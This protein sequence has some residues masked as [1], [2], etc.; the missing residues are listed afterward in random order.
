MA[1]KI[2]YHL[3]T[4][5]Y[6]IVKSFKILNFSTVM[7]IEICCPLVPKLRNLKMFKMSFYI[8]FSAKNVQKF[9]FGPLAAPKLRKEGGEG[10]IMPFQVKTSFQIQGRIGLKESDA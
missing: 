10:G 2:R 9:G 3:W 4:V 5:P 6:I 1:K 7:Y 8:F